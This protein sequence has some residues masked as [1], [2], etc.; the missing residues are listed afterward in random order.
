M[1]SKKL[2]LQIGFVAA[3]LVMCILIIS[4]QIRIRELEEEK[5]LLEKEVED[6]RITVGEMAY[7][8]NLPREDYIE[9]YAREVLGYHKFSDTLIKEETD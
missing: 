4:L 8:Y 1:K 5:S 6:Y 7:D 9:K 3:I 2:F